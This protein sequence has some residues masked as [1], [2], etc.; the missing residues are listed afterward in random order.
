MAVP[1]LTPPFPVHAGVL[2]RR[3]G[4]PNHAADGPQRGPG[5]ADLSA[6]GAPSEGALHGGEKP[7]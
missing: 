3:A 1:L 6:P 4:D 7:Q 5:R 2:V